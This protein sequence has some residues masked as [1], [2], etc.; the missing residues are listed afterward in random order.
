MAEKTNTFLSL[1]LLLV[2]AASLVIMV[3]YGGDITLQD[4]KLRNSKQTVQNVRCDVQTALGD[5]HLR[6]AFSI[7]SEDMEQRKVLLQNLPRIKHDLQVYSGQTETAS[8]CER[9]DFVALKG[10]LMGIV[11]RHSPRP[12]KA[13]YIETFFY[14]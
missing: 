11:N 12:V 14:D 4:F 6:L 7:A 10:Y 3:R 13:L 1:F 9:R 8:W 2:L 5:K